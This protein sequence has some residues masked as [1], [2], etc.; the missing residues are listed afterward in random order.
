MT[1]FPIMQPIHFNR[2]ASESYEFTGNNGCHFKH[3]L[4]KKMR[5]QSVEFFLTESDK[6]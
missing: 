6:R 5:I 3:V 1:S 2:T 4:S